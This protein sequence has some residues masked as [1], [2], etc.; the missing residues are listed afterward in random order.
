MPKFTGTQLTGQVVHAYGAHI[1]NPDIVQKVVTGSGDEA[2]ATVVGILGE[3]VWQG[4]DAL[5]FNGRQLV[6]NVDYH[7]HPGHFPNDPADSAH[8]GAQAVDS[9]ITGGSNYS[10]SAYVVVK[11]P[12]EAVAN[13]DFSGLKAKVKA[14]IVMDYDDEGTELGLIYTTNP[15]N[16]FLDIYI[17]KRGNPKSRI[18]FP[19]WH[20]WKLFNAAQVTWVGGSVPNRP[21]YS[22]IS[23]NLAQGADSGL[24]KATGGHAWNAG[25]LTEAIIPEGV[26]GHFEVDAGAGTW[27]AGLVS[28]SAT[29]VNNSTEF[30]I[31]VQGNVAAP[32]DNSGIL[33]LNRTGFVNTVIGT[34]NTGDRFKFAVEIVEGIPVFRIYKYGTALDTGGNALPAVPA[35]GFR[36]AVALFHQGSDILRSTFA[37]INTGDVG[38]ERT[39]QRFEAGL[40]FINITDA[41]VAQEAILYVSC[42]NYQDVDGQLHFIVPTSTAVPRP[43]TFDFTESNILE[44]TLET[45]RLARD[46]RITHLVGKI[47]DIDSPYLTEE[48]IPVDR[49]ALEGILNR[50]LDGGE[51]YLGTM[52]Q[53]QA[54]CVLN[55]QMR[56]VS[57]LDLFCSFEADGTTFSVAPGDVVNITHGLM[58]W[59]DEQFLV[60][61]VEDMESTGAADTRKYLC[62]IFNPGTYS[63]ADQT[64]LVA[65]IEYSTPSAMTPAPQALSIA[66]DQK[67]EWGLNNA[68]TTVVEGTVNF[69]AF[70]AAQRARIWIKKPS[71]ASPSI[72]SIVVAPSAPNFSFTAQET[73]TYTV[74]AVTENGIGYRDPAIVTPTG[75]TSNTIAI[76][77]PAVALS[78]PV[79][80]LATFSVSSVE[81]SWQVPANPERITEYEVW[82]DISNLADLTKRVY[83]GSDNRTTLQFQSG[84]PAS[85]HLYVRS[86]NRMGQASSFI[87]VNGANEVPIIQLTAPANYTIGWNGTET[88]HSFTPLAPSANVGEYQIATDSGF[89][90]IVGKS[91]GSVVLIPISALPGGRS[92]NFYLRAV[93]NIGNVGAT[94]APT[95]Q[96]FVLPTVAAPTIAFD[97]N[98]TYPFNAILNITPPVSLTDKRQVLKTVVEVSTAPSFAALLY[99]YYYDGVAETADISGRFSTQPTIYV[100]VY[101]VDR[102]NF[103]G[104]ISG[105][106]SITFA[107]LAAG[108]IGAGAIGITQLASSIAPPLIVAS[109][110]ALPNAQYPNNASIVFNQADGRL[111]RNVGNVWTAAVPTTD[112]TGTVTGAQIANAAI[113]TAKFA[114]GIE[115]VAIVSSVPGSKSTETIFNTTD[116][117]LYKWNGSAYVIAAPEA[118]SELAGTITTTQIT[119]GAITTP[120][121]AANAITADKIA[122]NTITAAQIA[123]DTIT[124]GQIAA[125]AIG[126]SELAANSVTANAIAAR[127]ITADRIVLGTITDAEVSSTA[128]FMK[129]IG[130]PLPLGFAGSTALTWTGSN[131]SWSN[132]M[133]V[134]PVPVSIGSAG[135]F[136]LVAGNVNVPTDALF[137]MRCQIGQGPTSAVAHVADYLSYVPPIAVSDFLDVLVGWRSEDGNFYVADGRVLQPGQ[138]IAAGAILP[139]GSIVGNYIAANTIQAGHIAANTITA[140]EI[141]AGAITASE[142]AANSVVA[143]KIAAAAVSTNEL[144]ANAVTAAKIAADSITADKIAAETITARNLVVGG[145]SDNLIL[146]SSF[147]SSTGGLADGWARDYGTYTLQ[148]YGAAQ[149]V[150]AQL[151]AAVSV[152]SKMIPVTPGETIVLQYKAWKPSGSTTIQFNALY[153]TTKVVGKYYLGDYNVGEVTTYNAYNTFANNVTLNTTPTTYE[154]VLTVPANMYWMGFQFY[155]GTGTVNLDD[156]IVKRQLGDAFISSLK[157][158]KI[159]ADTIG[160]GLIFADQIKQAS[161]LPYQPGSTYA[162]ISGWTPYSG[163]AITYTATTDT[164]TKTGATGEDNI[165]SPSY[166]RIERGDG[167]AEWVINAAAKYGA[168]GLTANFNG[169]TYAALDFSWY[170]ATDNTLYIYEG[171]TIMASSIAP[172]VVGDRLKIAIQGNYVR[173]YKNDVLLFTS[174]YSP[175]ATVRG[176]SY[177]TTGGYRFVF[178]GYTTGASIKQMKLVQQGYGAGWRLNPLS[179][180]QVFDVIPVWQD[181]SGNTVVSLGGRVL[182]KVGGSP[183]WDS[184]ARSTQTIAAGDG[185]FEMIVPSGATTDIIGGITAQADTSGTYTTIDFGFEIYTITGFLYIYERGGFSGPSNTTITAGD[186]IRVAIEGGVVKYRKNGAVV[187]TSTNQGYLAYPMRAKVAINVPGNTVT[188]FAFTA[189]SSGAGEFNSGLTIVGQRAEDIARRVAT[190]LR[191]DNRYRGN[192]TNA[193]STVIT[194]AGL[195]DVFVPFEDTRAFMSAYLTMNDYQ[196]NAAKNMDSID[197]VRVRAYNWFGDTILP[198]GYMDFPFTGRGIAAALWHTRVA[199]DPK[200]Q[201]VYSFELHNIYGYSAPIYFTAGTW[202][203]YGARAG[204]FTNYQTT[205]PVWKDRSYCPTGLTPVIASDTVINVSW[206]QP[207]ATPSI[208]TGLYYRVYNSIGGGSWTLVSANTTGAAIAV[209]GLSPNTKYEFLASVHTSSGGNNDAY[210]Y[211]SI[212]QARTLSTTPP[213]PSYPAPTGVSASSTGTTTMN[214]AWTANGTPTDVEISRRNVTSGGAW[215]VIAAAYAGAQPYGDTGLSATTTYAYRIRNNYSGNFSSY[216]AEGQ[217][218]THSPVPPSNTPSNLQASANGY[219]SI[220]VSWTANGGGSNHRIQYVVDAGAGDFTGAVELTGQTSP[221]T[222]GLLMDGVTYRFRVRSETPSTSDW[223]NEAVASTWEY[224]EED[225]GECVVPDTPITVYDSVRGE[226]YQMRADLVK[227]GQQLI[228]IGI[229]GNPVIGV[230]EHVFNGRTSRI[231]TFVTESGHTL[232]CSP[233][234]PIVG[235]NSIIKKAYQ[236]KTNDKV[237]V[238]NDLS[239]NVE[240]SRIASVECLNIDM[241]VVIFNLKNDEHT[242]V[243]GGIVSH[244]VKMY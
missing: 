180:S 91:K 163:S 173:Y 18:H 185:Y 83:Y 177:N 128:N 137:V 171:G 198:L 217:G 103:A 164:L 126:V 210:L 231:F 224:I 212:G 152:N 21:V 96:P 90:S 10:G 53:A 204:T 61:Q 22:Y 187:W 196:T 162:P 134:I 115:P 44:S 45:Y 25:A 150:Y 130:T 201:A 147:E 8:G 182:S 161:Y 167:Y 118:F 43:S 1:V 113:T 114:A 19:S 190:T 79:T 72:T 76:T 86:V 197:H 125:G 236:I 169:G 93:D 220:Q 31:G 139:T 242:F 179:G 40:A 228:S 156:V 195:N 110:P 166:A 205:P 75:Y 63:D 141:G 145:L 30:L 36:G 194:S 13:D 208:S 24:Y 213:A 138:T 11:L 84:A 175:T 87:E 121:V 159:S 174:P 64:P 234:H 203:S 106:E 225:P 6:L 221:V 5:Y 47:R 102:T 52:T 35:G 88:I 112:L 34:W 29:D 104:T 68:F 158:S 232:T 229:D 20:A 142:L 9:W 2:I 193:P 216:S 95:P 155:N 170:T 189:S 77:A 165:A 146:N 70:T 243:S 188:G 151:G 209:T 65:N 218:T 160:A 120:K 143:G 191:Y 92:W 57:D 80:P 101:Y 99:T 192:D 226:T 215:S 140:N 233:T 214:V 178:N 23:N 94:A 200:E 127:Q 54:K 230:V 176:F 211:S 116:K 60:I 136:Y 133:Y 223:S 219:Y 184:G 50:R 71:Q 153:K 78:S 28:S 222:V 109:L 183:A 107:A 62:Q 181:V 186:T 238:Y 56:M 235:T 237:L 122:A 32:G 117:K 51:I 39:R 14:L 85:V 241:P 74:Y 148:E 239:G 129:K 100:R 227:A 207:S 4:I 69:D 124:A 3:G 16:V 168:A 244:N 38:S 144:A 199:A 206:T 89:T 108:D 154:H 123:A 132:T 149:G 157:A 33:S 59:E 98:R 49:D 41:A 67:S 240:E 7:F 46:Q 12:A 37:P 111:Y 42:A 105:T 97:P 82:T 66:L 119:D 81:I 15:A 202:A 48:P 58:G 131:F 55:Y 27:S 26:Q 135:Y 172:Y 17:N 73:G